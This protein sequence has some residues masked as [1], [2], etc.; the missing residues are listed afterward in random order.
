[1][2]SAAKAKEMGMHLDLKDPASI[3]AWWVVYP[4]QHDA[5]LDYKVKASPQFAPAIREALRRIDQDPQLRSMRSKPTRHQS[6]SHSSPDVT[7]EDLED[8]LIAA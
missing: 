2:N 1:V 6:N 8:D 5:F 3:V 7:V 4:D